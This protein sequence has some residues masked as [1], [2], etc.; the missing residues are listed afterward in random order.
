VLLH[1]YND[2]RH[3]PTDSY[4]R[5]LTTTYTHTHTHTHTHCTK[6]VPVDAFAYNV[7][8]PS[9]FEMERED[10]KVTGEIC[11]AA[12]FLPLTLPDGLGGGASS[13]CT[14]VCV[15]VCVCV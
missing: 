3:Q 8:E 5:L 11:L 15:C 14:Y 2:R 4:P 12:R 13:S 6:T 7:L 9:W 10:G 1:Q